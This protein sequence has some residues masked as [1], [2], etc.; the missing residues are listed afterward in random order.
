MEKYIVDKVLRKVFKV[1]DEV[2][3]LAVK[4]KVYNT[5]F[6]D[7]GNLL[8]LDS[9]LFFD[10]VDINEGNSEIY[11]AMKSLSQDNI[12][13]EFEDDESAKLWFRLNYGG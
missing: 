3:D 11:V 1:I 8:A 10:C 4:V 13:M 12:L 9:L 5:I 2:E 7:K 6:N